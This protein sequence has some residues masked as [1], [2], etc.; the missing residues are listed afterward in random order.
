MLNYIFN[1]L[2]AFVVHYGYL[3]PSISYSRGRISDNQIALSAPLILSN[4][5]DT[6]SAGGNG[7]E[8]R[9]QPAEVQGPGAI[10]HP[11]DVFSEIT[12]LPRMLGFAC[13]TRILYTTQPAGD[14]CDATIK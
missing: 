12:G 2:N 11:S 8:G 9:R 3:F 4:V 1:G 10:I 5:P 6:L 14:G 13:H 7:G